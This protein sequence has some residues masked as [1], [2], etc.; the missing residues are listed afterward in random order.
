VIWHAQFDDRPPQNAASFVCIF[1]S[2]FSN[3]HHAT[4]QDTRRW[5][6]ANMGNMAQ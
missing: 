2:G 1:N 5:P 4:M 3:L 6:Q